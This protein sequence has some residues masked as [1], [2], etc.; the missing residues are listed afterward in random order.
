MLSNKKVPSMVKDPQLIK[1]RRA[2][3]VKGAVRL[4][5][6]KGFHRTTTREIAKE[7]GFSIGTLYEYIGAKEDILYLVCDD[8]Y[9]EVSKRLKKQLSKEG[10]ALERLKLAI[11]SYFQIVDDMSDEVLVMYQEVKALPKESLQYVL[12][13][14]KEMAGILEEIIRECV[15]ANELSVKGDEVN[16]LAH[17]ILVQGQMWTFRRWALRKQYTLEQYIDWQT[18][19]LLKGKG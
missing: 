15:E 5:I 1:V 8:I 4:F 12:Q 10:S 19:L 9:L 6:D 7:A 13:K 11:Y 2:Q 14:E 16:L 17:N 3:M 18:D